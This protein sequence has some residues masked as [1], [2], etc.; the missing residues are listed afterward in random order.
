MATVAMTTRFVGVTDRW[1]AT[2]TRSARFQS[3][4][5]STIQ[6]QSAQF[7]FESISCLGKTLEV[8]EDK[9]KR[10]MLFLSMALLVALLTK[11]GECMKIYIGDT[12]GDGQ[13]T[14]E[15]KLREL[16]LSLRVIFHEKCDSSYST[17][18]F[19]RKR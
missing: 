15:D 12:M 7:V 11:E 13:E 16:I 6:Y 2:Q 1:T 9:M 3:I 8:K 10:L 17:Q 14:R 5:Q 4:I 18:F 19:S